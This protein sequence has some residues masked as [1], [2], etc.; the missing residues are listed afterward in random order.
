MACHLPPSVRDVLVRLFRAEVYRRRGFVEFPPQADFRL[1]TEGWELTPQV[2]APPEQEPPP[3]DPKKVRPEDYAVVP[4][5]VKVLVACEKTHPESFEIGET[6]N[7]ARNEWRMA[8]PR[9]GGVAHKASM[10]ASFKNGKSKEIGMWLSGFAC[11]PGATMDLLGLEYATSE[12]EFDYLCEALLSGEKPVVTKSQVKHFHN[13]VR[14]GNMFLELTNGASFMVSSWKNKERWRGG[15]KTVHAFNEI[16]QLPGLEAHTGHAQNLRAEKGFAVF[17]S[18]PDRPWVKV[19]HNMAHGH[20]PDWHCV[21][22]NNAYVNPFTFDLNGLMGDLPDW[23]TLEEH[24]PKLVGMCRASGLQPGALMSREKF[25]ISWLGRIGGFVG[26]V[27]SFSRDAIT[28]TPATHPFMF[29]K[30]VVAEWL[31]GMA[32]LEAVR[33]QSR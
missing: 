4:K 24:A 18:T 19:L 14:N 25:L 31:A 17:T 9:T 5:P 29:K 26:R 15:Q 28:C 12:H 23:Q 11:L 10:L 8:I 2:V 22:D 13:D 3:F 6:G 32:M 20:N 33:A 30:Q 1:A 7:Y 16:Y 21:C 27:Y